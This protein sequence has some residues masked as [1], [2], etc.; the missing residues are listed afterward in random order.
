VNPSRHAPDRPDAHF[1]QGAA[2][3]K[4]K[5]LALSAALDRLGLPLALA[6]GSGRIVHRT[7]ALR[8][9]LGDEPVRALVETL[10]G[11]AAALLHGEAA[12]SG[13]QALAGVVRGLG[14]R[15]EALLLDDGA[16]GDTLLALVTVG[17]A[18]ASGPDQVGD[19]M[20]R[21]GMT[22]LE[23]EV[24]LLLRHRLTNAE[25]ASELGVSPHTV[26][27]HAGRVIAKLGVASRRDI[28][29]A[30]RHLDG[31]R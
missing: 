6:E 30:L 23:A 25:V 28:P 26:R 5:V 12:Q 18:A 14:F 21:F 3:R 2:P 24:A 20:R 9:L 8:A 29:Q 17:R 27:H 7:P 31:L 19:L 16:A 10:I 11:E 22:A 4:R 13:R 1:W 15:V